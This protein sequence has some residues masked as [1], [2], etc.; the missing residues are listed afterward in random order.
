MED[1]EFEVVASTPQEF[2]QWINDDTARWAKV[3]KAAHVTAN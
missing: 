2:S 3:I 1:M